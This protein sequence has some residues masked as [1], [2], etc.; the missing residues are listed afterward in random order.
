MAQDRLRRVAKEPSSPPY[1][2]VPH[3]DLLSVDDLLGLHNTVRPSLKVSLTSK[4]FDFFIN[5]L[6]RGNSD[7]KTAEQP[8]S[9]VLAETGSLR[10]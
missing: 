6:M 1:P 3:R 4:T 2:G 8:G 5:Q 9:V 10:R 7:I